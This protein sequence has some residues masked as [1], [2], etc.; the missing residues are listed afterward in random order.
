MTLRDGGCDYCVLPQQYPE[1][2]LLP[3]GDGTAKCG[4]CCHHRPPTF[5]GLEALRSDLALRDGE[6]V[7]VTVSGGKD[8][9]YAWGHLVE[10]FGKDRVVAFNHHKAGVVHPMATRNLQT[11]RERLGTNLVEV[12]DHDFL[13]RCRRNL[14]H[15]LAKPEPAM[16]KVVLC[17]GCRFGING[18][19]FRAGEEIG[20]RKFVEASSYLEP[21]SYKAALLKNLG[22]GVY[23]EGLL[24]GLR[25][26]P[27]YGEDDRRLVEIDHENW[28]SPKLFE[29]RGFDGY[30]RVSQ[31]NFYSY[32][33]NDPKAIQ[34][35]VQVHLAW[36]K[37]EKSWRFDCLL[38]SI[39]GLLTLSLLGYT[40]HNCKLSAMVRHGLMDRP[41]ALR[42]L[43]AVHR[44]I[45]ASREATYRVLEDLGMGDLVEEIDLLCHRSAVLGLPHPVPARVESLDSSRPGVTSGL[46]AGPAA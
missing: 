15:F 35:W 46:R 44:G 31:F 37:P 27:L 19:M 30:A 39:K 40:E 17:M 33:P 25:D 24:A 32:V 26:N 22:N 2:D 23:K 42:R 3:C 36:D 12:I 28:R 10:M 45:A 21:S 1:L 11:A 14:G 34:Q 20:I 7:G 6:K 41:E 29:P 43:D 9:L 8:S 4:F 18:Q 13:P 38:S 16:L 5:R